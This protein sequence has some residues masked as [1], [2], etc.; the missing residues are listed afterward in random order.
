MTFLLNEIAR[1][2]LTASVI[3]AL[4]YGLGAVKIRGVSLVTAAI[5]LV[6]LAFGHFGAQ[7]PAALQT[8]GLLLFIS[9]VGL[10]AGPG[11]L[12]R[13]RQNGLAYLL[14]CLCTAAAG[15][16]VC[17]CMVRLAKVEA[18]LAV[19]LMTGS[20]TTSP[21]FAAAREAAPSAEAM[22][23][24]AAGYGVAYPVGVVCKVLAIQLIPRFLH[25]DMARERALIA[26]PHEPE[27]ADKP[28]RRLD[29]WGL[30]TFSVT[31][32]L[33]ILL[34]AVVIRLPGGGH[35]SLGTT[36]G[37]LIVG[38]L[39]GQ[40]GHVGSWELRPDPRLYGPAKEL[41]LIFFFSGAGVEGGR[42]LAAI[43]S[44][45][46]LMLP[47]YAA[48]LALV[49]LTAG[50]FLFRYLLKLP[51]LNGLGSLTA[52]MTCTPSLAVLIQAA[53]TDDVAAAYATTYPLALITLVLLVQFLM[54]L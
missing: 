9:S 18:P 45:Y 27:A 36:G 13:M 21:G 23:R 42:G 46:G 31:V 34:G 20:F 4:G 1:G 32:V 54:A 37:P 44:E 33:G 22:G 35:F 24:V 41:G 26:L 38:L 8:M 3:A 47:V 14:I 49:P 52:S 29:P 30:S 19:G 51:L 7:T 15:A 40:L 10:S 12:Q 39:L 43:L 6:G 53:G 28:R 50:F 48:L 17:W 25:A 16:L 11:F 2:M 5:F